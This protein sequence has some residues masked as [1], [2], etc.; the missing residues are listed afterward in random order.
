MQNSIQDQ[1]LSTGA[2]LPRKKSAFIVFCIIVGSIFILAGVIL[3]AI[4]FLPK[5]S[6]DNTAGSSPVTTVVNQSPPPPMT[7]PLGAPATF[8]AQGE[9]HTTKEAIITEVIEPSTVFKVLFSDGTAMVIKITPTTIVTRQQT[10]TSP[11]GSVRYVQVPID[12]AVLANLHGNYPIKI[13]YR[14][15]ASSDTEPVVLSQ[16]SLLQ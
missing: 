2:L 15:T 1:Q 6:V 8:D 7:Y 5:S 9:Q 16:L 13:A 4:K 14:E 12:F 11:D 10:N 3:I